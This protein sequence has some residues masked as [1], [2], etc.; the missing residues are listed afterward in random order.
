MIDP[1]DSQILDELILDGR[2]SV[3]E[4]SDNLGLP[5]ATVQE[6]L[7]KMIRLGVIR[8]FVAIPDYSKIGKQVT[9]Y[10]FVAFR[11]EEH[12]SQKN[13]A[14][15]ISKIPGIYEVSVISGQWDILLKVRAGSVEEIGSFVVER[16]RSMK[17][18]EKTETCIA[19][20]TIKES[21]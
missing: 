7:N 16:L 18:I 14:E 19:F 13:L 1:K 3:V 10:V 11:S 6:R 8:K 5:R 12:V 17:G 4:I 15:Q 20:Q 9:A 2:K 21:F